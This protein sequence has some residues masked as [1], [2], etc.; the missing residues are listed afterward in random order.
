[1]SAAA[2]GAA[3]EAAVVAVVPAHDEAARVA[4]TVTALRSIPG[5][6]EVVVVDDGSTDATGVEAE[7]AGARVVRLERRRGK[8][9]ALEAGLDATQESIVL[10]ADADLGAS[11]ANLH[12]LVAAVRAGTADV[13]V[14]TPPRQGGASGFGLVEGL[15]RRGIARLTGRTLDRPLSGQRA[16]RREVLP[17][18]RP[19]ASGFGV[20]TGF[21]VD[22]LRAGYRVTE[23]PCEISH[24]RTGRDPAGFV[25][26]ARQGR[27]VLRALASRRRSR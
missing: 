13:A 18:I 4:A 6:A 25:H 22:A 15:A 8:G 26:R 7:R 1:M 23:V 19:L 21:T 5:V 20:E 14:A 3:G 27:D 2:A 12:V 17:A 10:L 24:A 11:A 16:L 9:G